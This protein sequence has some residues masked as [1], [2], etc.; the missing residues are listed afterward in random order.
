MWWSVRRYNTQAAAKKADK[1]LN[2]WDEANLLQNAKNEGVY[3]TTAATNQRYV[4]RESAWGRA[5]ESP[6]RRGAAGV[7]EFC[8]DV[9]PGSLRT[10]S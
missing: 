5:C 10:R 3:I 2:P 7:S 4:Y 9:Q 8:A 6:R 1:K